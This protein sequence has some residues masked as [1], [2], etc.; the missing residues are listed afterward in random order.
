MR[1]DRGETVAVHVT[2]ET[3][4]RKWIMAKPW[5]QDPR[6]SARAVSVGTL[7]GIELADDQKTTRVVWVV[8]R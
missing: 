4:S 8:V 1:P 5:A 2:A 3:T 6:V 7:V